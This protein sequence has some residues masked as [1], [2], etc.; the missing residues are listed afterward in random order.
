MA[1]YLATR[2]KEL[3]IDWPDLLEESC[4]AVLGLYRAG[5]PAILLCDAPDPPGAGE[6]LVPPMLAADGSTAL[7]GE[8]GSA[9]SYLAI[10]LAASLHTGRL[11]GGLEPTVRVVS[12]TSTGSGTPTFTVAVAAHLARR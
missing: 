12:A 4:T 10:A 11:I 2:T 3:G 9:T 7:F 1:R 8:G 5:K 6:P